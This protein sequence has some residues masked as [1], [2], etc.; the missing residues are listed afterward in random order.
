MTLEILRIFHVPRMWKRTYRF[1]EFI[2]RGKV[3]SKCKIYASL[4]FPFKIY[5]NATQNAQLIWFSRHRSVPTFFLHSQA[6][7]THWTNSPRWSDMRISRNKRPWTETY[8]QA[9]VYRYLNYTTETYTRTSWSRSPPSSSSSEAAAAALNVVWLT[10][11]FQKK[12]MSN[13]GRA[14]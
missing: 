6:H 8:T 13:S 2:Y 5:Q 3:N 1:K 4:L 14:V 12:Q 10:E 7:K 11:C 9:Q